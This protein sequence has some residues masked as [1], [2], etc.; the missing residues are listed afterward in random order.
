MNAVMENGCP[1]VPKT[2]SRCQTGADAQCF[3]A[4]VSVCVS[5]HG[6]GAGVCPVSDI[7]RTGELK[8]VSWALM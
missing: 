3:A 7:R 4:R 8:L 1:A 2:N 5:I 6:A